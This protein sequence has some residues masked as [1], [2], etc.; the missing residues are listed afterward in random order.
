MKTQRAIDAI[1]SGGFLMAEYDEV[2]QRL[3]Y[4]CVPGGGVTPNQA[5]RL[6]D[7]LK[8]ID[9]R[10]SLFGDLPSQTWRMP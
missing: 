1:K 4:R 6:I 9:Q 2:E 10:D 8:L 7:E 3:K 5:K